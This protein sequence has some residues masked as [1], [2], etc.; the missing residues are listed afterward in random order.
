MK[1]AKKRALLIINPI[2]GTISKEGLGDLVATRLGTS[3]FETKSVFTTGPGHAAILASAASASGYDAV[4]AAGGDGTVNEIASALRGSETTLGI[5]PLGSGNGLARHLYNS[6]DIDNALRVISLD[7]PQKCD[8]GLANSQPFFC[9]F[10]LGFDARVS[11]EF[12]NS[13]TRGLISY[14]KSAFQEFL[15]YSPVEYE[16]EAFDGNRTHR[17]VTKAFMLTVCNSSQ[18]GNN[19]YIA[20]RAS[21]RDGL[22]DLV[23]VH[24]GNPFSTF[25]AG[26]QLFAGSINHNVLIESLK[27][28]KIKI[29][30]FPGAAHMD[31]EPVT[32]AETVRVECIPRDISLFTDPDKTPFKPLITPMESLRDDSTYAIRRN[33]KE[34]SKNL[35]TI[36]KKK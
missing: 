34:A 19:A 7:K 13:G 12:A 20:P 2:S 23:V 24:Q 30:H 26:A 32:V 10:G 25:L 29:R 1:S 18:F 9:T 11:H 14:I 31:G 27:A 17:L 35:R 3:G 22:L 6:I 33:L 21:I 8:Y 28:S 16:I 15:K 4:I 5:L 36:F